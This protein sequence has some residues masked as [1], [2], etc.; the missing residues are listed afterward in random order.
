MSD[1]T[2]KYDP[3]GGFFT[4]FGNGDYTI[5]VA[6]ADCIIT[7]DASY[8]T[9]MADSAVDYTYSHHVDQTPSD[10]VEEAELKLQGICPS[11]RKDNQDHDWTC[12]HFDSNTITLD[13]NSISFG[14]YNNPFSPA[15]TIGNT[16]L[17]ESKVQKIDKILQA[18]DDDK[19]DKLIKMLGDNEDE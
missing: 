9:S 15:I 8:S 7:A 18:L 14:N 10:P 6:D 4:D 16:T 2:S 17:D 3:Y 19:L 11:C 5:N 12:K 1:K 13:P